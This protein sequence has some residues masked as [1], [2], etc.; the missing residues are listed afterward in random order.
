MNE[1]HDAIDGVLV[2]QLPRCGKPGGG[3][4][5]QGDAFAVGI[6]IVGN[7]FDGVSEGVT[8]IE[9]GAV[10][11]FEGV[12]FDDAGFDGDVMGDQVGEIGHVEGEGAVDVFFERREAVGI[13]DDVVF[14]ALG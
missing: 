5:A 8:E 13:A 6:R 7:S 12:R 2:E 1:S 9:V 4:H 14:D 10:G 3:D 11:F